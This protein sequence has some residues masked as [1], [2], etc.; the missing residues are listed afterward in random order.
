[1]VRSKV[2]IDKL[3]SFQDIVKAIDS[4][5]IGFIA[6]VDRKKKLLGI[7]TD[8]DIRKALLLGKKKVEDII[9][10][11]PY[12]LDYRTPK[13]EIIE[14]LKNKRRLQVPLVDGNNVLTDVFL[15]NDFLKEE[16]PNKVVIMVGG[17]GS[18][19]G[20]ITEKTPKPMLLVKGKPILEYI[21]N[22]FKN[23][24]FTNFIL[25]VNYKKEIIESYFKNG[26]NLGVSITYVQEKKRMGTA[27]ALSL[28][29]PSLL[30][31]PFFVVNGD[32]ISTVDYDLILDF[33]K[34]NDAT[35][36]MCV[37]EVNET[38]PYAEVEFDKDNNLESLKEK[39][40]KTFFINLGIYLLSTDVVELIPQDSF[41]D[42][43]QL[44]LKAKDTINGVKVCR[45]N[46][47]WIDIGKPLDLMKLKND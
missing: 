30:K 23:Q 39:P 14:F 4:F 20:K 25:C 10:F 1:M 46:D 47:D 34:N 37:K 9:N 11:N 42:M 6:V 22:S 21:I 17:L 43:P 33:F 3:N 18:R 31:T 28:I 44:F 8:G 19:L 13:L 41:Y 45:M 2:Y 24:G 40:T 36:V 35:A 29:D 5:G 15:L 32:V 7:V 38:N 12:T 27:G 26:E 16:R